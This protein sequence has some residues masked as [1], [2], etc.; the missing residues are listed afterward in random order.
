MRSWRD[1]QTR[2]VQ[3]RVGDHGGSN[4]FDRTKTRQASDGRLFCFVHIN[5]GIRTRKGTAVSENAQWAFEQAVVQGDR[6]GSRRT[7]DARSAA[8]KSL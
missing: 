2:T 7:E 4:P 8:L 5:E 3:V 6:K 1:W